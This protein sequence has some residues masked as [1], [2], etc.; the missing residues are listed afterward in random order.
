[1]IEKGHV[2]YDIYNRYEQAK[3]AVSPQEPD[4]FSRNSSGFHW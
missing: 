3:V 2:V 1:M 4:N